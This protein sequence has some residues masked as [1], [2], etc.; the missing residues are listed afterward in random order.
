MGGIMRKN[1]IIGGLTIFSAGLFLLYFFSPYVVE[2][3]K[4]ATQPTLILIGLLAMAAAI[5]GNKEFKKINMIVSAIFLV[6]GLYGFY[7]EYYAVLDFFY[8]LTP[9]LL[10]V[11]GLVSIFHGIKKLT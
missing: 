8:G 7:D 4:G 1:H 6:L 10:V 2:L 9:P 11:A 5:F 3:I